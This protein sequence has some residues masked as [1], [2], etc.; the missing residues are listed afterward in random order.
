MGIGPDQTGGKF[1]QTGRMVSRCF[2]TNI[3]S[4]ETLR[5][6]VPT[7]CIGF[8]GDSGI[9]GG[10][11]SGGGMSWREAQLGT[12]EANTPSANGRSASTRGQQKLAR[13]DT[14]TRYTRAPFGTM[15]AAE[16]LEFW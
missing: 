11:F 9:S 3:K 2:I 10:D 15:R 5:A 6:D 14:P 7:R 1:V 16:I 4:R 8:D 13:Y 12:D